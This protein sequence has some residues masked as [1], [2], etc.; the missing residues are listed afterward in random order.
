MKPQTIVAASSTHETWRVSVKNRAVLCVVLMISSSLLWDTAASGSGNDA[1]GL[2]VRE[3]RCTA[4]DHTLAPGQAGG[5]RDPRADD[6]AE[7]DPARL[8]PVAAV[9]DVHRVGPIRGLHDRGQ[10]NG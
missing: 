4:D 1:V 10:G 3:E 9:D 8:R 6:R 5:D 2:S 7:L